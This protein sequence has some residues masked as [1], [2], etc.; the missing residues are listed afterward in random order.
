MDTTVLNINK[1]NKGYLALICFVASLGGVLFGFDTAVIS[2][3][4]G[5]VESF[6]TLDKLEVGW[7]ASSALI[8]AIGGAAISGVLS[9]SFGRKPVLMIAALL[10][11]VSALG[12]MVPPNFNFLIVARLIG[13]VG[14]GMASVLAPLYISEVAPPKIRGRLVAL[15][16]LSIVIGI[17]LAYFSNWSLLGFSRGNMEAFGGT[18]IFHK[19]MVSEVWRG[20]FG[21][22]MIP[23]GLFLLL[24]FLIPESPRW[25]IKNGKSD[26]G[27]TILSKISGAAVAKNELE[28]IKKTVTQFKGKI[29]E[30]LKPGLRLALIVGIGLSVFGQFTGVNIIVYYG[31]TILEDAGFQL[32]SALQFQVAIGIINLIFTIIALWKIDS[33]GRRPLLIWGMSAVFISLIIIA[34]LFITGQTSGIWIVIILC[35][36]MASL[37]ISINAV[38]WV[39]IGEI[40]P[41]RIRGRAMSIATFAN[42]GINF[43]T[44]FLF[45]WYVE[46]IGVGAGFFTFAF[47][48]LIATIFFYRY[49]PE[50]KGKSLE[51]IE[52]YWKGKSNQ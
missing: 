28:E 16:Q 40:F 51:E 45:P 35:V 24:L 36:Y 17:L 11:F 43:L 38:I 13:G 39:L 20:M 52:Q 21:S 7:F 32:D 3:T 46:K 4:F 9:D 14:V 23:S 18:G 2:G 6:F 27:Y 29:S 30:L 44:A 10:F 50:T 25:L 31:P 49:V 8:G 19:T 37:A 1:G 22:E 26:K 41:T 47:M 34:T 5:F 12:S 48:C 42:W 33:W 15:Y